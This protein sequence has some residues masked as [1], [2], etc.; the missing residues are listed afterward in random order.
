MNRKFA[1]NALAMLVG[2]AL[3]AA[4][5]FALSSRS[6]REDEESLQL[7]AVSITAELSRAATLS[8]EAV[9]VTAPGLSEADGDGLFSGLA[10]RLF[11][12]RAD[13]KFFELRF[14]GVSILTGRGAPR[15]S[16]V[17]PDA[18]ATSQD[19]EDL[20]FADSAL[21][22]ELR[23]RATAAAPAVAP[24]TN[25][26]GSAPRL[27]IVWRESEL[28]AVALAELRVNN[29]TFSGSQELDEIST[30]VR[31]LP[32]G[33]PLE[34]Q[35]RD[36]RVYD[37]LGGVVRASHR[38][39]FGDAV[40]EA[41]VEST[42]SGLFGR[43]AHDSIASL[44]TG[45]AL[46]LA[47]Y[48]LMRSERLRAASLTVQ[49]HRIL[50]TIAVKQKE[51]KRAQERFEHLTQS[52]NV[53]P[54]S[55]DLDTQVFTYI[56]PQIVDLTGH[57]AETWLSAGFWAY[58]IHPADRAKALTELRKAGAGSYVTLEYR[59]RAANGQSIYVRNMLSV[60]I[61]TDPDGRRRTLAQGFLLDVTEMQMAAAALEE[62]KLRAEEANRVKSEFLANMSHE[63]RTP[64]N[65]VI[66]FSEIMKDELFGKLPEQYLEYAESVHASGKHLLDLINDVLDLSKIEAGR[67][68]L[69][70]E[71]IDL[72][73]ILDDC[74]TLLG[75]RMGSAGLHCQMRVSP[76]LPIA[77]VDGRRI[78]QVV[79]NL[80]AN[81]VKFT[82]P[83]GTITLAGRY[84]QGV[85]VCLTVRDT[86]VGMTEEEIPRALSKFGQI[87]GDLT[88]AH[89]GTGLGLPIAKSLIEMHGG[90][91]EIQSE[92]GKGTEVRIWLPEARLLLDR[93][94]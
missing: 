93:A 64:L 38:S 8:T 34:D 7:R 77:R 74:K 85:G 58:H 84:T 40:I 57:P 62:G 59:L 14:L 39:A 78:K 15:F 31:L 86:G 70:D 87:D 20:L 37:L 49:N 50:R 23:N 83:G 80:M 17:R 13:T 3:A 54:W 16:A 41:V 56:G 65:A 29:A 21:L 6:H 28:N 92:K 27:W 26:A 53:I 18:P 72:E 82:P 61:R 24:A 79:L 30:T 10:A 94:A 66:G 67:V 89:D 60:T 69:A 51:L 68:E 75:E 63:L 91:L 12:P 5:F 47:L 4:I 19:F 52:T 43:N 2:L 35:S 32:P 25:M 36:W 90:E 1:Q 44:V 88:R 9:A 73:E 71:E 76:D 33:A 81:A 42:P 48:V 22:K 11:A 55:A 46:G 45:I